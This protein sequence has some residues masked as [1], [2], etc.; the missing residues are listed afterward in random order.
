MES[1]KNIRLPN[2]LSIKERLYV[3]TEL[4]EHNSQMMIK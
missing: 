2:G 4:L 3:G 1:Y